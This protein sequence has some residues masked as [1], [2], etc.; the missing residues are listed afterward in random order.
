MMVFRKITLLSFKISLLL[1]SLISYTT[2]TSA[3]QVAY[4][5]SDGADNGNCTIEKP[6]R[7]LDYAFSQ[8]KSSPDKKG[9]IQVIGTGNFKPFVITFIPSSTYSL[10]IISD[11][12]SR[13]ISKHFRSPKA[14]PAILFD[15]QGLIAEIKGLTIKG[16]IVI[17]N[18]A[19][20]HLTENRISC[21]LDTCVE[22]TKAKLILDRNFIKKG[23]INIHSSNITFINNKI[24]GKSGVRL[25]NTE[26]DI[27]FNTIKATK[28]LSA[29][30]I[31]NSTLNSLNNAIIT[32]N[33]SAI[34]F[35][36]DT[37]LRGWNGDFSLFTSNVK[38]RVGQNLL[39]LVDLQRI[40]KEQSSILANPFIS[41]GLN[42]R[43]DSPAIDKA[44]AI[45]VFIDYFGN[46]RPSGSS[47][48][49]GA[50]EFIQQLFPTNTP[51]TT[52]TLISTFTP[53]RTPQPGIANGSATPTITIT[54][55][56]T[57]S[58]TPTPIIRITSTNTPTVT[59]TLRVTPTQ[60]IPPSNSTAF[61]RLTDPFPGISTPRRI[62][63]NDHGV[64]FVDGGL[65][66]GIAKSS[67][68]GATW[69][70]LN[71]GLPSPLP[72]VN[73]IGINR[74]GEPIIGVK[75]D[76]SIGIE[77]IEAYVYNSS[78]SRWIRSTG[79]TANLKIS[80]FALNRS[81]GDIWATVAW[82]DSIYKSIDDGR[83]FQ[84]IVPSLTQLLPALGGGALWGISINQ[85][86]TNEIITGGETDD[87]AITTDGGV[88]WKTG[89][90]AGPVY[91]HN[92]YG[93]V[94]NNLGQAVVN[95]DLSTTGSPIHVRQ[96]NA[97]WIASTGFDPFALVLCLHSSGSGELFAAE[98]LTSNIGGTLT[99]TG[100]LF[101]SS[102]NGL[103]WIG[104]G[105]QF[106][107][108]AKLAIAPDG[109]LYVSVS[110][111]GA[112][113]SNVPVTVMSNRASNCNE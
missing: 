88:T 11:K 96:S 73:A 24:L 49:I 52:P 95:R 29:L 25:S 113:R 86:N 83:T 57:S 55:T 10:S 105:P 103:H 56:P 109:Y 42:I 79:I 5:S 78:I 46:Q 107:G 74:Q 66:G 108:I 60:T 99:N 17:K 80:Q 14:N 12:N 22:A 58:A 106:N 101:R 20:L 44:K 87:S 47:P 31:E 94:Y 32:K 91:A 77:H 89:N 51:I 90:I 110:G 6:C 26:G 85:F 37:D 59:P 68:R 67:D 28:K 1:T 70:S 111:D 19:S 71:N 64:I 84:Q 62:A 35:A 18:G 39:R 9:R 63:I 13:I 3:D 4:I 97:T 48:D 7:E 15:S 76:D 104:F 82:Q 112:Y 30:F 102:D 69:N 27:F 16:N 65:T 8:I 23:G 98:T 75:Y 21:G 72:Q 2:I 40:G 43:H 36:S 34:A 92:S 41:A 53:T 33:N 38:F 50:H 61:I 93:M 81:T 100:K 45:D 54:G